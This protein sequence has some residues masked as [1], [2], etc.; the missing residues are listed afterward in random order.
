MLM[1]GKTNRNIK[2]HPLRLRITCASPKY[3]QKVLTWEQSK[4]S[5]YIDGI[6]FLV[7]L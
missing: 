2:G 4:A 7:S 6:S 5:A 1:N 3:Y